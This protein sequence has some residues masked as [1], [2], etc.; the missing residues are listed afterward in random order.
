M[1]RSPEVLLRKLTRREF[2]QRMDSGELQGCIIPIGAIEQHLEH[3]AMEHDWRSVSV[4]AEGIARRMAPRVLVA[5]GLMV[6]V[7]EHH[8]NHRGTLTLRPGTFLNV[9][10]DL[11]ESVVRAGFTNVLVLNGHGGNIQPVQAVWQ[12]FVRRFPV[13][14]QFL[15]Y[16]AT[17]DETDA[18]DLL[19]GGKTCPKHLPGHAQEFETSIAL[20]AFPENVRPDAM[21]DQPDQAPALATADQ[22]QQFLERIEDRV[23]KHLEA[24]LS[25]ESVEPIPPMY[26]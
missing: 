24:M 6:G 19:Q 14:L 16:F 8:M 18:A 13:N 2:R 3:L 10:E 21:A 4:V 9:L 22:G 12:Q 25:G 11:I 17:L 15:S 20:A 26:P 1:T 5:E 23:S 7:S